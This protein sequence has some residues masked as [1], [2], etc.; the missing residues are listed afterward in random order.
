MRIIATEVLLKLG[1]CDQAAVLRHLSMED[2]LQLRVFV[3][4]RNFGE[5][6]H[7]EMGRRIKKLDDDA[8]LVF[9]ERC[10]RRSIL[11]GVSHRDCT[12][13][14][15]DFSE[16]M[17][18]TDARRLFEKRVQRYSTI[19]IL[20]LLERLGDRNLIEYAVAALRKRKDASTSRLVRAYSQ[21]GSEAQCVLAVLL[22]K[23]K[24]LPT[25]TLLRWYKCTEDM[26]LK[27][28]LI[29]CLGLL[30]RGDRLSTRKLLRLYHE[31]ADC[32]VYTEIFRS[33]NSRLGT[34]SVDQLLELYA[35][36]RFAWPLDA[37]TKILQEHVEALSQIARIA[38]QTPVAQ[39]PE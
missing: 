39:N 23:K 17:V 10:E 9:C 35:V 27:S 5:A 6:F 38:T 4:G 12:Y 21:V 34:L 8:L 30:K 25:Q 32:A 13:I 22:A 37:I 28:T 15:G 11:H 19:K 31:S 16:S 1:V 14:T 33:L 2:L 18:R 36:S 26:Q 7:A 3:I 24:D 29:Y 20:N